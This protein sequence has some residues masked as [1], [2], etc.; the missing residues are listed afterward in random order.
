MVERKG[1][2]SP[3]TT[4]SS[5]NARPDGTEE[6]PDVDGSV[7]SGAGEE[8]VGEEEGTTKDPL[9][10]RKKSAGR[11]I[12]PADHLTGER[13]SLAE[14]ARDCCVRCSKEYKH[15]PDLTCHFGRDEVSCADC[16]KKKKPCEVVG[17]P[18]FPALRW[19]IADES[20]D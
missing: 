3:R 14:G 19:H 18:I 15:F 2:T 5:K 17:H 4:R 9:D 1:T 12:V 7:H 20:P 11:T 13:R 6:S 8:E 10:T 16:K